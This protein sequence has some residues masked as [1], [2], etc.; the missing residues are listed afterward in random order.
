MIGKAKLLLYY[1]HLILT[2]RDNLK[3][4]QS[5]LLEEESML[6]MLQKVKITSDAIIFSLFGFTLMTVSSVFAE[7]SAAFFEC[8][9]MKWKKGWENGHRQIQFLVCPEAKPGSGTW[10]GMRSTLIRGVK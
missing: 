10:T 5:S 1:R 6:Q 7:D 4:E 2:I 9:K 3:C 8:Q